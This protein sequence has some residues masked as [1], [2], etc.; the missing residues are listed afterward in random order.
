MEALQKICADVAGGFTEEGSPC[1]VTI[2]TTDSDYSNTL[3]VNSKNPTG[4]PEETMKRLADEVGTVASSVKVHVFVMCG[5]MD[6]SRM[7]VK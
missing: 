4:S 6:G 3:P 2:T 7:D 5:G 1:V